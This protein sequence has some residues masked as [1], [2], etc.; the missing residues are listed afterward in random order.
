MNLLPVSKITFKELINHGVKWDSKD[1]QC[2]K[3]LFSF[4]P[5]SIQ[6]SRK[7]EN[8]FH[9]A[10]Q[11]IMNFRTL[12]LKQEKHSYLKLLRRIQIKS[13]HGKQFMDFSKTPFM[14]EELIMLLI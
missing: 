11:S 7:E 12:I 8:T 10:G 2:D 6:S 13:L 14:V 3:R 1:L 9:K 5:G 4:L